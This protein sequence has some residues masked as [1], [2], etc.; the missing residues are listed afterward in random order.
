L[1]FY[2]GNEVNFGKQLGG[3][4]GAAETLD[5][6]RLYVEVDLV[7]ASDFRPD[8]SGQHVYSYLKSVVSRYARRQACIVYIAK[9]SRGFY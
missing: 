4:P 2:G 7:S 1:I 9:R 5:P 6:P 8:S 3:T